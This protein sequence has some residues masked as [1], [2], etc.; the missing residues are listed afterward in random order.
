MASIPRAAPTAW[1]GRRRTPWC[2]PPSWSWSPTSSSPSSSTSS[3]EGDA[4]PEAL[5]EIR[6]L[7]K[8][9]GRKVV[10]DGLDFDIHRG[11]CLVIL[12]RSGTGKSVTL[13]QLNGLERPDGGEVTFDGQPVSKLTERELLPVRRRVAMLFQSGA[14]FDSM[15]VFENIAFPLREHSDLDEDGIRAKVEE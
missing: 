15:D 12:G 11:E 2:W 5:Y 4:V 8:R 3:P 13:R 10:L 7:T 6:G 9:Y 1:A 14:L